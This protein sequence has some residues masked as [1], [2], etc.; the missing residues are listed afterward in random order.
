MKHLLWLILLLIL[1]GCS[2]PTAQFIKEQQVAPITYID[3]AP[4]REVEDRLTKAFAEQVDWDIY[5]DALLKTG[6]ST[7][8]AEFDWLSHEAQKT[9]SLSF[10]DVVVA[11]KKVLY[12]WGLV[13]DE[14][15]EIV[16]NGEVDSDTS[17]IY[18]YVRR[19]IER[20]L[21]EWKMSVDAAEADINAKIGKYDVDQIKK[22]F[23]M[24]KPFIA[25]VL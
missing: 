1:P 25:T 6:I 23:D 9:G 12:F 16:T 20:A 13:R 24:L 18:Y 3:I 10:Y 8:K 5:D 2:P 22:A 7:I 14:L 17:L 21:M 15:D 11:N 19:D 4:M